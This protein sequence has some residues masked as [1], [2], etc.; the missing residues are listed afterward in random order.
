MNPVKVCS[1]AWAAARS[2]LQVPRGMDQIQFDLEQIKIN[3]GV[4]LSELQLHRTSKALRDYEFKVFSQWGEDGIIQHLLRTIEVKNKT[5]IEFG[6]QDFSESN[7]RFL[8]MKD[9]W[10]GYVIDG[11]S[12]NIA[13]LRGSYYFWRYRLEAVAAFITT[14]NI[15]KLLAMSGLDEDLGILSVDIDGNDYHVLEAISHFRPRILICEYNS[16]FGS[17]RA[18][19]VPYASDFYRTAAHYSNLYF[20]AS[21]AAMVHIARIKGYTLVG[22]NSNGVN[23]FFVR[24]DLVNDSHERPTV[25][26]AYVEANIRESRGPDGRQT[27]LSGRERLALI[28]GLPVVNVVSG[29]AEFL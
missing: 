17:D 8:L 11:S 1:R 28:A 18:I 10:R 6:V 25:A 22:T 7:C 4:I 14:D 29:A 12:R 5:F 27:Y 16:V 3:Q 21:L 2:F 20:G 23:A 24:N 15:D 13:K 26:E 19:S 9:N